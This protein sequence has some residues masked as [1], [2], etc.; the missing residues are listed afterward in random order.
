MWINCSIQFPLS[1]Q[2][3][4]IKH[5]TQNHFTVGRTHYATFFTKYI[6]GNYFVH[7][8]LH[9]NYLIPIMIIIQH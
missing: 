5:S 2:I 1:L 3:S 4:N 6:L 7:F 8:F 9:S